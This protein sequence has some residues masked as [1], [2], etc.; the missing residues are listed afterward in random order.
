MKKGDK[1]DI[2][3]YLFEVFFKLDIQLNTLELIRLS[4]EAYIKVCH[5]HCTV[6]IDLTVRICLNKL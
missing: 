2:Y 5:C 1:I 3:H 4:R 6:K